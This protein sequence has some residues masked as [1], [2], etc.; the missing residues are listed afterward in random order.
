MR[1]FGHL[2]HLLLVQLILLI[3]LLCRPP[4]LNI[5][6]SFPSPS[7]PFL[8]L[9]ISLWRS[10]AGTYLCGPVV[11]GSEWGGLAVGIWQSSEDGFSIFSV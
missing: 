7:F 6:V 1:W 2:D 11:V 8:F 5:F 9:D 3:Q 4:S 10:G